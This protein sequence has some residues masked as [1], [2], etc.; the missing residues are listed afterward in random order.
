M[1]AALAA[2]ESLLA[3]PGGAAPNAV[4]VALAVRGVAEA[5]GAGAGLALLERLL[6]AG[7]AL[8]PGAVEAVLYA[9]AAGG[10]DGGPLSQTS[11]S[12]GGGGGGARVVSADVRDRAT[13]AVRALAMAR[14]GRVPVS[15]A[16]G[17]L[18]TRLSL[19]SGDAALATAILDAAA[20]L[21]P[22]ALP[23]EALLAL[24]RMGAGAHGSRAVTLRAAAVASAAVAA[25]GD[26]RAH[27]VV[28]AE[29]IKVGR[30]RV[31]QGGGLTLGARWVAGHLVS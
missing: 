7:H 22:R 14:R 11:A 26:A 23:P 13:V 24:A 15:G 18:A 31:W 12:G 1:A 17:P 25:G 9:C 3:G 2:F 27:A 10:G 29:A 16:L 28:I 21:G 20:A 4:S 5:R 6:G 19:A 8:V 30:A